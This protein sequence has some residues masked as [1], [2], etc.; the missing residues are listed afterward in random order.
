MVLIR[1]NF[2]ADNIFAIFQ[3]VLKRD[4]S[5]HIWK[6]ILFSSNSDEKLWSMVKSKK[7]KHISLYNTFARIIQI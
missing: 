6:P 5:K 3:K 7:I 1:R 2:N 4:L